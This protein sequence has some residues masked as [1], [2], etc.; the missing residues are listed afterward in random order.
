MFFLFSFCLFVLVLFCFVLLSLFDGDKFDIMIVKVHKN[1]D[2]LA[3]NDGHPNESISQTQTAHFVGEK[4][5]HVA[6]RDL[7]QHP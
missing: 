6:H 3:Q 5:D 4:A 7:T 2:G 1:G